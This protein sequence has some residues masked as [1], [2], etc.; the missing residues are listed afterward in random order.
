MTV[1]L[2]LLRWEQ[3]GEGEALEERSECAEAKSWQAREARAVAA[4]GA[5]PSH[6]SWATARPTRQRCSAA[7]DEIAESEKRSRLN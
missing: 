7:I 1:C 3:K 6:C 5:K 2:S 4:Q